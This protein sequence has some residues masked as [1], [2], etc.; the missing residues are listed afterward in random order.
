MKAP[1]SRR[2]AAPERTD[3]RG[4]KTTAPPKPAEMTEDEITWMKRIAK[5]VKIARIENDWSQFDLAARASVTRNKISAIERCAEYLKVYEINRVAQ[6]IGLD[7]AD[8]L[9]GAPGSGNI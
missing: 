3:G 7:L 4:R 2:G 1:A 5:R 8:L 6:A 9:D